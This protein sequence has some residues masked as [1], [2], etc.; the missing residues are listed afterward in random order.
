MSVRTRDLVVLTLAALVARAVAVLVVPWPPFTDPA[1]YSLVAQRLADG[2]GFTAPVL[3]SF[4]EVGSV[5]PDP[6]V[7]PVPS[8]AHW[9]P[10]TSIVAAGSMLLFGS[11]Y[12]AGT[13]PL[14]V[15]S[16]LLVPF[17]YLL[18]DELF[19]VRWQAIAAAVLAL[20]AG[21]LLIMYP[22]TDNFA[23][24]GAAGAAS[25]YCS[26]RAV[27]A[28]A[29]GTLA[30]CCRR[31]RR[32]GDPGQD[33]R[34]AA[35][36]RRRG[37]LVHAAVRGRVSVASPGGSARRPRSWQCWDRGSRATWRLRLATAVGGR[38]HAVDQ[39]SYNEQ[40]CIGHDV[41]L[42]SYLEWGSGNIIGSKLVLVG[43]ARRPDGSAAGRHLPVFFVAGLWLSRRRAELAPFLVYFALM[44]F[45]MGAIFTFHAPKGAFYHSAPAWLPWAFAISVAAV[46]PACTAAGRVWPFLRRPATHR[47]ITVVGVAGAIALSV[48]GSYPDRR[49]L[50][51]VA[52]PRRAGCR[53]PA[54][55]RGAD[56]RDHRQRPGEHLS[57]E[58]Q[59]GRRRAV[60]SIPRHR[61][62]RR[63][64]RRPVGH[65]P[66][67][68]TGHHRPAQPVGGAAG[69]DSEG[70]H[71]SFLPDTPSF[72]GDDLRIFEVVRPAPTGSP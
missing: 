30:S 38:A 24:F 65:R 64:L 3:W 20:F 23:V 6:A 15:L 21:P 10:L 11:T 70:A 33:R 48:I 67:R 56:R 52:R 7:L 42:A 53:V 72:E 57:A 68:R 13:L 28:T 63:C 69:I 35:D 22:T 58:R 25:L 50:G 5:L 46:G 49:G 29:A 4:I 47:F 39:A 32:P 19:G 12:V 34:R 60:R 26:M 31:A 1:Y 71:P 59:P 27:R 9:M 17:T 62:G 51:S 55:Q 43:R 8:N 41:S 44:F 45:A 36:R 2:H 16:A 40:F 14:I 66:A 37:G 61:A 18:T 54:R